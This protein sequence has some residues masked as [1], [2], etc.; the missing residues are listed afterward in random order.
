ME[1]L[2][3]IITVLLAAILFILSFPVYELLR[4]NYEVNLGLAEWFQKSDITAELNFDGKS[5][6]LE[7][8]EKNPDSSTVRNK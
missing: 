3:I 7:K 4:K 6:T 1:I 8:I 2:L 5:F